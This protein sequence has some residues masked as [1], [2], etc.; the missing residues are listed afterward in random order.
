MS[1]EADTPA[2]PEHLER[3]G[4]LARLLLVC[5]GVVFCLATSFGIIAAALFWLDA[6]PVRQPALAGVALLCVLFLGALGAYG[7]NLVKRG[8]RGRSP[9]RFARADVAYSRNWYAVSLL[10]WALAAGGA[11]LAAGGPRAFLLHRGPVHYQIA[12]HGFLLFLVLP[13]H[14]ALHELGHAAFGALVGLRFSMLRVGWLVFHRDG[15]GLHVA[16]NRTTFADALGVHVG[17]PQGTEDLGPRLFVHAAGGPATTLAFAAAFRAGA[18]AMAAPSTPG[19]AVLLHLLL[20]GWWVGIG[21]GVLNVVPFRTRGGALTDG[22]LMLMAVLPKS[23][24]AKTLMR[25]GVFSFQGR[26]PRDWGISARSLLLNAEA[27]HRR[28]DPLL[29]AALCVALDTRDGAC[30]DDILRRVAEAPPSQPLARHEFTLQ[31][32]MLEALRGDAKHARARIAELGPHPVPGYERLAE[33][34]VHVAEGNL[35]EASSALAEWEQALTKSGMRTAFL[36][37]NEWAVEAVRARL[38]QPVLAEPRA[39]TVRAAT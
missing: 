1:A 39:L 6:P 13:L 2:A 31:S 24:G 5:V 33:A 12:W 8:I 19:V 25:V 3:H 17:V 7:A 15:A 38:E 21:L 34:T 20:A 32:A 26:R 16:W 23:P 18:T 37:G 29:V 22:A 4:L 28:R 35:A 27:E 9:R 10:T 30:V 14:V 11:M 36:V